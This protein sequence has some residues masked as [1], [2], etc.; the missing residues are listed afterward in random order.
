M[1]SPAKALGLARNSATSIWSSETP[2]RWVW[3][4]IFDSVSPDWTLY[5]STPAP[6]ARALWPDSSAGRDAEA[7]FFSLAAWRS[8][9]RC[10]SRA[11]RCSRAAAS[12]CSRVEGAGV[13]LGGS[14]VAAGGAA[15]MT[16]EVVVPLDAWVAGAR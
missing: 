9:S 1:F 10:A 3:P 12:R 16:G 6:D 7:A 4:A 2:G 8:A 13:V 11:A 5:S 15:E 14:G